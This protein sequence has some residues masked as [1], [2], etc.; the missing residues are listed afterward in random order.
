[1]FSY[2]AYASVLIM[3]EKVCGCWFFVDGCFDVGDLC[4]CVFLWISVSDDG[5]VNVSIVVER[6][7]DVIDVFVVR[8]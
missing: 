3:M 1:M 7:F 5:C 4:V 2:G 6:C 8:R